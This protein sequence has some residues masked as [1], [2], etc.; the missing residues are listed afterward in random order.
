MSE[1]SEIVCFH[2]GRPVGNP[3]RLNEMPDGEPCRSCADRLLDSLPPIFHAPI[4]TP[5][6]APTE[7]TEEE[8]A[9]YARRKDRADTQ[10]EGPATFGDDQP[11]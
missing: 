2:C 9:S 4:V 8:E 1:G 7:P 3:P 6:E 5:S 11:A 10:R